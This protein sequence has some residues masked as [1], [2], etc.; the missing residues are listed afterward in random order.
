MVNIKKT[1][2]E[3]SDGDTPDAINNG[4]REGSPCSWDKVL[5]K[6]NKYD[7]VKKIDGHGGEANDTEGGEHVAHIRGKGYNDTDADAANACNVKDEYGG[8]NKAMAAA[9]TSH[10][11]KEIVKGTS[12]GNNL[13]PLG[14]QFM[15]I[16]LD[17]HGAPPLYVPY[18]EPICGFDC[19]FESNKEEDNY[20]LEGQNLQAPP[21]LG[22]QFVGAAEYVFNTQMMG[23]KAET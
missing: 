15:T 14:N 10:N 17:E 21:M 7:V 19:K 2:N 20:L 13:P 12:K 9:A 3:T 8:K 23:W 6:D 16:G 1:Y 22:E 11:I 18:I 5:Y 4:K